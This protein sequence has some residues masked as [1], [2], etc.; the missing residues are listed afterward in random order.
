[1]LGLRW[2]GPGPRTFTGP[3]LPLEIRTLQIPQ[4]TRPSRQLPAAPGPHV[5]TL[6]AILLETF[7]LAAPK[8]LIPDR[9]QNIPRPLETFLQAFELLFISLEPF[10]L[11]IATPAP[12]SANHKPAS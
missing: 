3:L 12:A 11:H 9:Q 1:M 5:P 6:P 10:H 8:L 4:N 2:P 7:V